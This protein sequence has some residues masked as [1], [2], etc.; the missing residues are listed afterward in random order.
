[1][2]VTGE[3]NLLDQY[4]LE[5]DSGS[6]SGYR[7]LYISENDAKTPSATP[8]GTIVDYNETITPVIGTIKPSNFTFVDQ[9]SGFNTDTDV[10]LSKG[11]QEN[12]SPV[13]NS[14]FGLS[15]FD[16]Q[17]FTKIL[18]D[19]RITVVKVSPGQYVYGIES[20]A[21]GV[22]EGSATGTFTTTKTL[23]VKTLFGNFKSGESH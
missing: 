18:L 12:G 21:Y 4:F 8:F 23:M 6:P 11:R 22:V 7:E 13:Y 5:Y 15:Y 20:G 9:G 2:T 3:K 17:F 19:E 16:P 1:M 14:T 10:V